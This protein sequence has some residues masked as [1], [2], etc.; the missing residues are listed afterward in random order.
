[1]FWCSTQIWHARKTKQ[2]K[3]L[4]LASKA[5]SVSLWVWTLVQVMMAL[6]VVALITI[7]G[8]KFSIQGRPYSYVSWMLQT[9]P[10]WKVPRACSWKYMCITLLLLVSQSAFACTAQHVTT[11]FWIHSHSVVITQTLCK[12]IQ[13]VYAWWPIVFSYICK[14]IKAFVLETIFVS[15]TWKQIC[16]SENL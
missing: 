14:Y 4:Y 11:W 10:A 12:F 8:L 3:K 7:S 15:K 6:Q 1:M 9:I 2:N 13:L 16:Y 5:S